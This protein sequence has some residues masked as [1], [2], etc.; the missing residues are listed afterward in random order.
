MEFNWGIIVTI[1]LINVVYVTLNTLRMMLTMKG[2]QLA[3]PFIAMVEVAIYVVGLG[4]VL[5]NLDNV[6]NI[7]AYAVGFGAGIY[8]GMK[9]EDKLA[10]GH[11]LVTTIV[12]EN[13]WEVA[14]K[15][16]GEGFGVTITQAHGREGSRYV[17]EILTP[18]SN[19]RSLYKLIHEI[20][21]K[22]FMI[23][24]EPRY[25]NGGFWTKRMKKNKKQV[26]NNPQ[27]N[28]FTEL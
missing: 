24:Y 17:L 20:E 19:E 6:A 4:L 21:P 14:E 28:P 1:L 2:Y 18:R 22:A 8:A 9:I 12:P 10:L 16:R 3:A 23:S 25:I 5:D 26:K 13:G 15:L 11:I 7:I 27:E